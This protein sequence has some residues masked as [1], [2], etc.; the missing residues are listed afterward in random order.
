[1]STWIYTK[2]K[3]KNVLS[4]FGNQ[5][6]QSYFKIS[7]AT[8]SPETKSTYCDFYEVKE[9]AMLNYDDRNQINVCLRWVG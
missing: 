2:K 3:G 8:K 9:Q 4:F 5:T 6:L 1:M 7:S